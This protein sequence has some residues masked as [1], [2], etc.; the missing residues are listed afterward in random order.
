MRLTIN[1]ILAAIALAAVGIAIATQVYPRVTGLTIIDIKGNSMEPAIPFGSLVYIEPLTDPQV[2]DVV[3]YQSGAEIVTH[4]LH[5]DM[6]GNAD[7]WLTK[8]DNN[9][10]TDPVLVKNDQ[11]MGRAVAYLPAVGII[12]RLLAQPV[13]IAFILIATTLLIILTPGAKP[14]PYPEPERSPAT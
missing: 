4:R 11:I 12:S 8:G 2:G 6:S 13:V 3:T 14:D 9:P 10:S 1:L 7:F 5:T